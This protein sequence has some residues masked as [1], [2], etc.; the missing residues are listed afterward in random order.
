M[1]PEELNALDNVKGIILNGGENR[2]VDGVADSEEKR[3]IIGENLFVYLK[4]KYV[5][6]RELI[7]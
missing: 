7:S 5:N 1:T 2:I 4:K 6:E 3:K